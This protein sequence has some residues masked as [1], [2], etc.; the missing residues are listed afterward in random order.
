M[1]PFGICKSLPEYKWRNDTDGNP[2]I[3]DCQKQFF[4]QYYFSPESQTLFRAL[5]DND[6]N[7]QDKFLAYWDVTSKRLSKNP[8]VVGYDPI[9][10]PMVSWTKEPTLL[11]PGAFTN[12]QLEP[13]YEK[14]ENL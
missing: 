8:Y 11:W 4:F 1:S 14:F 12:K 6:L 10:E 13:L 7:L 2:K 9:N 5:Y 3:E